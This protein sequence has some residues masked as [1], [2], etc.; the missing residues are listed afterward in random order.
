[1]ERKLNIVRKIAKEKGINEEI[2][3]SNVKG[4]RFSIKVNNKTINFGAWPY[5]AEGAYIDHK[6]ESIRK[7]WQARH[8]KILK[9]GKPAYKDK[10]SPEYYSWNLLW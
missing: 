8:S 6:D 10:S 7:A 5:K 9:D 1:M 4:K 2:N 3:I